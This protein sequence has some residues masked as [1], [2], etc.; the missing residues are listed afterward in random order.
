MLSDHRCACGRTG[1]NHARHRRA[2][3]A[4]CQVFREAGHAIPRRNVERLLRDTHVHVLRNDSRRLD[5]IVHGT[6]IARGLPLFCDATIVSPISGVA[7]ARPGATR[8]DGG[9]LRQARRNND[10]TYHEVISSGLG[11]LC[12]LDTEVYGRWG[13]DPLWILPALAR[14]RCLDLPRWVRRGAQHRLL[15]RWWSL[16]SVSVQRRIAHQC[17]RSYG[18]DIDGAVGEPVRVIAELPAVP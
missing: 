12:A 8:I 11:R 15:N 4:W 5:I 6:S 10:G 14:E 3:G 7:R 18:S 1:R 16:L 2:F 9:V 13:T 17:L